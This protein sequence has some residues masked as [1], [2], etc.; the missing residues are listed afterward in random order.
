VA[1]KTG[2]LFSPWVMGRSEHIWGP[3]ALDF[4]PGRWARMTK[5]PTQY[6]FPAFNAGPRLCLGRSAAYLEAKIL[7]TKL[8]QNFRLKVCP[9]Q[10]IEALTTLTMPMKH[11]LYV[12]VEPRATQ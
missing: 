5:Q 3:T 1:P 8:L 12:T 11:G 10:K 6:E 7:M 2:I 4:D 9:H